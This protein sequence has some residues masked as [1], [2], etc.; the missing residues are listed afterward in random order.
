MSKNF[1]YPHTCPKIDKNIKNFQNDLE[2]NLTDLVEEL[3][4]MFFNTLD[5]YKFIETWNTIIY[6]LAEPCFEDTR[7]SNSDMRDA[8]QSTI[9]DIIE[10]R[11]E[12]KR[13]TELWESEADEKD[14]Q[15]RDLEDR[16]YDLERTIT[17]F[18]E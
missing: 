13:L 4:P 3:N 14:N 1:Y 5:G 18:E 9:D 11:D 6:E 16:I 10:E 17:D 2:K 7:Q 12:Y 15:I 8:V